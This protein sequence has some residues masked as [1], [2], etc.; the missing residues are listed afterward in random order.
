M[1]FSDKTTWINTFLGAIGTLF[2]VLMTDWQIEWYSFSFFS[3]VLLVALALSA[4]SKSTPA[5]ETSLSFAAQ[6]GKTG[7]RGFLSHAERLQQIQ[8]RHNPYVCGS[9]LPGN[10]AM[11]Y[12]RGREIDIF[13][14]QLQHQKPS[15]CNIYGER[16]IGKSSFL[17][18]IFQALAAEPNLVSIKVSLQEI[19][20]QHPSDFFDRL[21]QT[22]CQV[23]KVTAAPKG[24]FD[25][26]RELLNTFA[27]KNYR[28]VLLL[29]E[30]DKLANN[31]H[32]DAGFFS[33]L[34]ALGDGI[35]YQFGFV[36]ASYMKLSE[37]C[38]THSIIESRFWNIFGTREPLGLL[39]DLEATR[40]IQQPMMQSL[41]INFSSCE[42]I[43]A[44]TG[45]HPF[46][47][48]LLASAH[49]NALK[50]KD[51][52][53]EDQVHRSLDDYYKEL[54]MARSESEQKLLKKI[55]RGSPVKDCHELQ[56][57]R[58]RGV[59]T[60]D[61]QLFTEYFERQVLHS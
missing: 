38:Q 15:N 22:L 5:L 55:A 32:F 36:I 30:F 9:A 53:T 44:Y 23:L 17:N 43:L 10:S 31:E 14:Q 46:F 35:E 1:N 49:W 7:K 29:D 51:K 58:D 48:Q 56:L 27:K 61:N 39:S 13:L 6:L 47:I 45:N 24:N 34:R 19:H 28:F 26:L 33:Q 2:T 20:F 50:R 60:A 52:V 41:A 42:D 25:N 37:L 8:K 4:R 12:G 18:Q 16:R 3:F 11:F 40:L 57:L 54:W 21:Y 59:L